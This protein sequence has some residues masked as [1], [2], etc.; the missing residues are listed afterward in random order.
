[1]ARVNLLGLSGARMLMYMHDEH[2]DNVSLH[3]NIHRYAVFLVVLI[4]VGFAHARP[5][6][7]KALA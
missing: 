7:Q 6:H 5:N 1:M 4:S 3:T 2:V